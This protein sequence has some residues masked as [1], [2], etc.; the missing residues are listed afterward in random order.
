M[1]IYSIQSPINLFTIRTRSGHAKLYEERERMRIQIVKDYDTLSK[2]A[3]Q[4]LASQVILKPRSVLGLATGSTPIGAYKE[5]IRMYK[6]GVLSFS[7][8]LSFNLDEYYG[9]DV[10]DD[11]SYHYFMKRNLFDGIDI[12]EKNIHILN[13]KAEDVDV[14]CQ[15]YEK[16]IQKCGGIDLQLLGIGDNGHIGFNEP[17]EKFGVLTRLVDL[18]E[19]TIK[20]NARFFDSI[21]EVPTQAISM[22]IKTI[23][24]S[25][26]ILLLAS[27]EN[28]AEAIYSMVKGDVTPEIPV[29]ILQ[30][31]PDVVLILDEAAASMLD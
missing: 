10:N 23:M 17:D 5:L 29:S 8:I 31:H 13:G 7:E 27:G 14:E 19:A 16:N 2:K 3:A 18:D 22:G 1:I 21:S 15:T 12:K 28:K 25:K 4:I 9:L 26:K 24:H 11:Q 20:A 6:E 30:L